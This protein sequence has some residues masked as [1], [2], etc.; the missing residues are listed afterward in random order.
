M[1]ESEAGIVLSF[2]GGVMLG[3]GLASSA[4]FLAF[5]GV[6]ILFAT[7]YYYHR[8]IKPKEKS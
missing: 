4:W 3:I 8:F 6:V 2:N 5:V 7:T 1:S